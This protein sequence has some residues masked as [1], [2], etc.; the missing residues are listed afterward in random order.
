[1]LLLL[2]GKY[3]CVKDRTREKRKRPMHARKEKSRKG[4]ETMGMSYNPRGVGH[5]HPNRWVVI[6]QG[7]AQISE[8]NVILL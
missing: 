7:S 2:E 3:G 8:N 5:P 4:K 6:T 1:M